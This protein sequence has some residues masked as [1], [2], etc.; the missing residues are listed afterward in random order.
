MTRTDG[1]VTG[2]GDPAGAVASAA[3]QPTK[4]TVTGWDEH[5]L[6]VRTG[7]VLTSGKARNPSSVVR[8]VVS[9]IAT[10]PRTADP[11]KFSCQW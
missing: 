8:A 3:E 9:V 4:K 2:H 1:T 11:D 7:G 6:S 5:P 10:V